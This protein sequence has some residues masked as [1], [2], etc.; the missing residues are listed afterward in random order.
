MKFSLPEVIRMISA[1]GRLVCSRSRDP[2]QPRYFIT[3]PGMGY[4]FEKG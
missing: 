2:A 1:A 4:R 3:E